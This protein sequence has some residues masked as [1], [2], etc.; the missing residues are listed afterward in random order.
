MKHKQVGA[1]KKAAFGQFVSAVA[2]FVM[3]NRNC[4]MEQ[5][6]LRQVLSKQFNGSDFYIMLLR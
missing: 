4:L 5:N 3:P 6:R 1:K 2:S